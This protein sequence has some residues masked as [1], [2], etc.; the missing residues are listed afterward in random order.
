MPPHFVVKESNLM[1]HPVSS[2]PIDRVVYGLA[3]APQALKKAIGGIPTAVRST[4]RLPHAIADKLSWA[5]FGKH[6]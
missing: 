4:G 6:I 5:W 3:D 1:S 2:N